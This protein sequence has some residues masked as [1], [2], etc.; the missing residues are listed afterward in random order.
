MKLNLNTK[1]KVIL[2]PIG[3]KAYKDFY[4]TKNAPNEYIDHIW[5][6]MEVFGSQIRI[7]FNIPF[8]EMELLDESKSFTS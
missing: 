2:T 3:K 6:I 5:A 1:A 4:N 8:A 7:G